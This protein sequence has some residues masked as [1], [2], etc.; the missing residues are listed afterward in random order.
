[1]DESELMLKKIS[2]LLSK[3]YNCDMFLDNAVA[4]SFQAGEP[5]FAMVVIDEDDH[6][7]NY[8]VAVD[9]PD[10]YS[11]CDVLMR[12]INFAPVELAEPFF[13]NDEGEVFWSEEAYK[14]A[15]IS[16]VGGD[17]LDSMESPSKLVN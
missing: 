14:E 10:P 8:S 12:L 7:I 15:G 2:K 9:A 17:V 13:M 6:S 1:M 4:V 11:I 5:H 16:A 3:T